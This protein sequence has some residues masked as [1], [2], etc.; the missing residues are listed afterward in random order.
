MYE[1]SHHGLES[2]E[3]LEQAIA[4]FEPAAELDDM[5]ACTAAVQAIAVANGG[6]INESELEELLVEFEEV[7]H[8]ILLW[9]MTFKGLLRPF[10]VNG[11]THFENTAKG[12]AYYEET[13]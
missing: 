5:A 13:V 6:K 10:R 4:V 12:M 1:L 7:R 11:E 2:T 8:Q 9:C 3:F